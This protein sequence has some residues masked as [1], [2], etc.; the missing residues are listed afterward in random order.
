MNGSM[1]CLLIAIVTLT[2]CTF[3]AEVDSQRHSQA[4]TATELA[5]ADGITR[6]AARSEQQSDAGWHLAIE[7]AT[8]SGGHRDRD[9]ASVANDQAL[10][11]SAANMQ[12]EDAQPQMWNVDLSWTISIGSINLHLGDNHQ[13]IQVIGNTETPSHSKGAVPEVRLR[14]EQSELPSTPVSPDCDRRLREHEARVA[15]WLRRFSPPK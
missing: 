12:S 3:R 15:E 6:S 10:A 5:T 14:A 11:V 8:E 9:E 2:G 7:A 1:N 4:S 13:H